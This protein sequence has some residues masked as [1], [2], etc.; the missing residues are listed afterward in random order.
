VVRADEGFSG[1]FRNVGEKLALNNI[2]MKSL[3]FSERISGAFNM[4]PNKIRLSEIRGLE[5][6]LRGNKF[7][8]KSGPDIGVR[9]IEITP[10]GVK[11]GA[12]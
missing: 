8:W 1:N 5:A 6:P 3:K 7:S 9:W 12:F 10:M 2:K 4:I 11:G